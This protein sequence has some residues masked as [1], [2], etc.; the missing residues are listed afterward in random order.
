MPPSLHTVAAM[1]KPSEEKSPALLEGCTGP[2]VD[3]L[4]LRGDGRSSAGRE[5]GVPLP[6][7]HSSRLLVPLAA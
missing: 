4:A 1:P 3:R 6:D 7:K 2:D 5:G